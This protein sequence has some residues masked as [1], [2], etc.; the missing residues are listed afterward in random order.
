MKIFLVCLCCLAL[1]LSASAVE[2]HPDCTGDDDWPAIMVLGYLKNDATDRQAIEEVIDY[3][4][5]KVVRL[6][7]VNAGIDKRLRDKPIM[8]RQIHHITYY[9]KSG[10]VLFEAITDGISYRDECSGDI[11]VYEIGRTFKN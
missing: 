7:S 10:E 3:N 5:Y 11:T 8:Y 1:S 9:K 2:K 6:S 4:K